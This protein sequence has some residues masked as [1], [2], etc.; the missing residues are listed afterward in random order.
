MLIF[1][2]LIK[3]DVFRDDLQ[4]LLLVNINRDCKN[5]MSGLVDTK[6]SV[7]RLS[8]ILKMLNLQNSFFDMPN[9]PYQDFDDKDIKKNIIWGFI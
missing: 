2:S 8:V 3:E 1:F 5:L 9:L 6:I 4:Y 7:M